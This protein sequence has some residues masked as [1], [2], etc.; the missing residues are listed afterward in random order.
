MRNGV[1]ASVVQ[2]GG[3]SFTTRLLT[4]RDIVCYLNLRT[5]SYL[6]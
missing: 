2:R 3:R 1:R 5:T 4:G 6:M